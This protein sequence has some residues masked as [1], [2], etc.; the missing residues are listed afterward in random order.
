MGAAS[1]GRGPSFEILERNWRRVASTHTLQDL[2]EADNPAAKNEGP[3]LKLFALGMLIILTGVAS[4]AAC[5]FAMLVAPWLPPSPHPL[6]A[7]IQGDRYYQLLI[8]LTVP[9]TIIAI[10]LNWFSMKLF[11]HNS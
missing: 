9:V 8:P 6:V 4:L 5:A 1:E 7:A 10:S 11:K 2:L 3:S